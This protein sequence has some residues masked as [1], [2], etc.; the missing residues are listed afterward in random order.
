MTGW[1]TNR[2]TGEAFPTDNESMIQSE[3]DRILNEEAEMRQN[4]NT[5]D[6]CGTGGLPVTELPDSRKICE[7]CFVANLDYLVET[8]PEFA[9][10]MHEV[11]TEEK[12]EHVDDPK[13]IQHTR[14]LNVPEPCRLC[15]HRYS[16]VRGEVGEHYR[17]AHP[18][19]AA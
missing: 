10:L 19:E 7:S 17:S 15:G 18:N 14:G 12:T 6:F 9:E 2:E 8:Y 13:V 4:A 5:C 1:K 11:L 3:V 16:G